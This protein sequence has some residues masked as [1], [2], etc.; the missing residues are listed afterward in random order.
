MTHREPPPTADPTPNPEATSTPRPPA[1]LDDLRHQ[2]DDERRRG[3][4]KTALIRADRALIDRL[5]DQLNADQEQRDRA[6]AEHSSE[7]DLQFA[8]LSTKADILTAGEQPPNLAPTAPRPAVPPVTADRSPELAA[9]VLAGIQ[10][11]ELRRAL[12]DLARRMDERSRE[13]DAPADGLAMSDFVDEIRD[14]VAKATPADQAAGD[15]PNRT[16]ARAAAR[17]VVHYEDYEGWFPNDDKTAVPDACADA[18]VQALTTAGLLTDQA[19]PGCPKCGRLH[20]P[21]CPPYGGPGYA[22]AAAS[23]GGA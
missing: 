4:A 6:W 7:A 18:V 21:W 12:T 2:L 14:L 19:A 3:T 11:A 5:L 17:S 13:A 22:A 1:V 15:D 23:T 9:G 8:L 16:I 10:A 20:H